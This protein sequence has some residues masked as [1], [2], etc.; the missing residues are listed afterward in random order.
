MPLT[1]HNFRYLAGWGFSPS[2]GLVVAGGVY[3]LD[4]AEISYNYGA[5]FASLPDLPMAMEGNCV[6]IVG[7]KE[8]SV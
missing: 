1:Y 7:N 6:V 5:N 3:N 8:P 4:T 2:V